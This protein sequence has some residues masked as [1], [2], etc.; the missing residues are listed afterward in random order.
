MAFIRSAFCLALLACAAATSVEVKPIEKVI[1]LLEDMKTKVEDEGKAEA[2]TYKTFA[3][4][5]KDQTSLKSKSSESSKDTIDDLSASIGQETAKK[6]EDIQD[7]T[8]RKA[9]QEKLSADLDSETVRFAK[10]KAKYDA[11]A[12]DMN[13]AI[14][15]LKSAISAM[16]DT[17]GSAAFISMPVRQGLQ[18]TLEIAD[19]MNMIPK[20]K[21]K[22]IAAFLQNQAGATPNKEAYGYHSQSIIDVMKDLL[23]DFSDSKK[24]LDDEW[25]K[26]KKGCEELIASLEGKMKTNKFAMEQLD[27]NIER[28]KKS[29]AE[30]RV[31]LVDEE[32]LLK[33]TELFLKDLTAR[34]EARANDFDQRSQMRNDEITALSQAL[35]VLKDKV[36]VA[37]E[38]NDR[39]ALLQHRH[40]APKVVKETKAAAQKPVSKPAAVKATADTAVKTVKAEAK[41][42]KAISFVQASMRQLRGGLSDEQRK[43]QALAVIAAGGKELKSM[44]L[45]AFASSVAGDPFKKV[46][47]LIQKLIERLLEESKAEATKK[48]FCDT[49]LAKAEHDRD[50]RREETLDI[51]AELAGLEAKRDFLVEELKQLKK[52]KKQEEIALKMATEDRADEKDE[53][54]ETIKTAKE[55]FEAVND[56][57]L[58][59]KK[60][61]KQAAKA[62]FVQVAESPLDAEGASPDV[63]S[64]SYKGQQDSSKAVLGLLETISSDFDRTVR[65]TTAAEEASARSY[66]EY[67]QKAKAEIASKEK[68]IELDTEDL[69]TTNINI[70]SSFDDL[71]DNQKLLD[72]ALKELEE[73]KPTCIDSGMSY[74]ERVEKRE[75][76][77]DHLKKAL[78]ILDTD[79]VE[80]EC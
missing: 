40:P 14:S 2:K 18:Q 68:K 71:E 3:C 35:G 53:N 11:E 42:Q 61:Y 48:G 5:C 50:A 30:D 75:D 24:D 76:E 27:K 43:E 64:G 56:A 70:E 28:L 44:T 12:A 59:L 74:A 79:G 37:D 9:K 4:F 73:L 23:K 55:G 10:E 32:A 66:E 41:T 49:E 51:N 80:P 20:P 54:L 65:T 45:T 38:A 39:A 78:C 19:M 67:A 17:G 52:S 34:C 21:N 29:I 57:L 15:S 60:F 6:E 63:A 47:G 33:D 25:A 13:K 62:S 58:I 1:S 26:T 69:K 8:E 31:S 16:Q 36:T 7:L 22:A 46:K 77:M 72:A